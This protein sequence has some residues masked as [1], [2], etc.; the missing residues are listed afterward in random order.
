MALLL[1]K[2]SAIYQMDIRNKHARASVVVLIVDLTHASSK[3]GIS[4]AVLQLG[5]DRLH[6][7]AE[8]INSFEEAGVRSTIVVITK[9]SIWSW[10][11]GWLVLLLYVP[12][13]QL[14]SLRDGQFT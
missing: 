13:Q 3:T 1:I 5:Y 6:W 10:L 8:L 7:T 12:S 14:W 2:N 11:V 9:R 4:V